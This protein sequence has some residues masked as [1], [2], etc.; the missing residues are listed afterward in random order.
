MTPSQAKAQLKKWMNQVL[1]VY[2]EGRGAVQTTK[3]G[4]L[5]EEDFL[6]IY[7]YIE[8]VTRV[9]LLALRKENEA[10]RAELFKKAFV[11]DGDATTKKSA[12]GDYIEML[13]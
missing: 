6:H 4:H 2:V 5:S 1:K 13:I 11:D 10:K 12:R 3:E 8:S 9:H 7:D